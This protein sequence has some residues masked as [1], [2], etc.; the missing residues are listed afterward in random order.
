MK[1]KKNFIGVRVAQ[2]LLCLFTKKLAPQ[3]SKGS[4]KIKQGE[5]L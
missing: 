5:K 1:S 2:Q 4:I 3:F